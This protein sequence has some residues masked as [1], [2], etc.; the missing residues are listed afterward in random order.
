MS[1]NVLYVGVMGYSDQGFDATLAM[2]ML[3]EA[4]DIIQRESG[5]EVR[6][7]SGY[8]N[9]GIPALAY[10]E[11]VRRGWKT[12]GVACNKAKDYDVFPCD[13]VIIVGEDW[14]DESQAFLAK[15][16]VFIQIGGGA[17]SHREAEKAIKS[18]KAV[19]VYDLKSTNS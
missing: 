10:Q 18:G 6:I 3:N 11:A 12:V 17:Q 19:F 9:L 8:T 15:C 1:S 4:F 13:K 16:E 14:G 7:V 5:R 2:K